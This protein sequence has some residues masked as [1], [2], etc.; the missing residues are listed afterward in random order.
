MGGTTELMIT[1]PIAAPSRPASVN[2]LRVSTPYSSTVCCRAVVSRQ[3]A[4][5]SS[6]RNTPS[7]VFVLPTSMVSSIL[8][9]LRYVTRNHRRHLAA[10]P[11]HLQ[12]SFRPQSS[13]RSRKTL[14]P[15]AHPHPLP[16]RIT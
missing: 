15:V 6:P 3:L 12:Q 1:P 2:R 4:I 11:P 13:G 8:R 5:N 10:V 7:T 16:L 14:F 9:C